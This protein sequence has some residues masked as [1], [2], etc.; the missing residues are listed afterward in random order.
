[1][2]TI[3]V[4]VTTPDLYRSGFPHELFDELRAQG[5][6]LHHPAVPMRRSPEGIEFWMVVRHE[7][8]LEANRDWHRFSA[9]QGPSIVGTDPSEEG[10]M[11]ISSDPPAHARLRKVIS[12]GFTPR[13][14]G[15]L[16]HQIE[17]WARQIL[18]DAAA[19]DS[20]DFVRDV[21][22]ALPMHVIADIVGIPVSDR[23]WIFQQTDIVMRVGDPRSGLTDTDHANAMRALFDYA[24]R[25]GQE[26]RT[27]P[28][29]DV[30][31]ILANAEL[32]GDDG[33]PERLSELE[34]DLFFLL[35]SAAGSETTRNTITSGLV[36]LLEH[37]DQRAL[38]RD[39]PNVLDTATEELLRWSSPVTSF[40]R[41]A[42][43]DT[44]LGGQPIRRGD[45]LT[46]WYPS[47]N[48]DERAFDDPHRFDVTRSPNHHVAFG[49]GGLHFC[50]G[51]ALARREIRTMFRALLTRFPTIEIVGEPTW[52]AAGP[53]Q[54]VACSIETLPVRLGDR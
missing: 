12:S 54:S 20:C 52:M 30:W 16:D 26:K 21:A 48:R 23:P 36:T 34:L 29:D 50:L 27:N 6:V 19:Q 22:Y 49:G 32:E 28:T 15:R 40:G 7:E 11:L 43:V 33:T 47:G 2:R 38:M 4:D 44:E 45:R 53:D 8:I 17:H 10:H 42:T 9:V 37:P 46:L 41:T 39:D 18:D 5:A 35:L 1:M 24:R 31:S 14:I 3:D 13:M 51:A 25:L